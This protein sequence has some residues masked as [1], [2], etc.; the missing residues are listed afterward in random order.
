MKKDTFV[1]WVRPIQGDLFSASSI[2]Y[3]AKIIVKLEGNL[4][5]YNQPKKSISLPY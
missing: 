3:S 2:V 4:A 1:E 5:L